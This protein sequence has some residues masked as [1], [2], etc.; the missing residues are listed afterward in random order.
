MAEELETLLKEKIVTLQGELKK[1]KLEAK[2]MAEFCIL[3]YE[4]YSDNYNEDLLKKLCKRVMKFFNQSI[5]NLPDKDREAYFDN[6]IRKSDDIQKKIAEKVKKK[7]QKD[8][9]TVGDISVEEF[10]FDEFEQEY[11]TYISEFDELEEKK[12][13]FFKG[14]WIKKLNMLYNKFEMLKLTIEALREARKESVVYKNMQ[15][16]FKNI[17]EN[18]KEFN[19]EVNPEIGIEL[20]S[21]DFEKVTSED[22]VLKSYISDVILKHLYIYFTEKAA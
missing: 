20:A 13:F 12:P 1:D 5:K 6:I 8:M 19:M 17:M 9:R 2:T 16:D 18:M 22:Y 11:K 3:F 10:D 4:K 21:I 14:G 7:L 15:S